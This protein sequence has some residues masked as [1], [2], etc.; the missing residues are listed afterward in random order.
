MLKTLLLFF[1]TALMELL[2]CFLPYMWLRQHGSV[3]LLPIAALCLLAFVYLL[4]LH[5]EASGRV[6]AA[7]G[8]VYVI[9]A[10]LWLR[11]VDKIALSFT[12][13]LGAAV[14]LGGVLLIIA[15]WQSH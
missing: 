10:L 2:G 13:M 3:W 6:Y 1:I 4:S 5:P 8:G 7:Y 14:I 15:P 11:L 12:D 9:S